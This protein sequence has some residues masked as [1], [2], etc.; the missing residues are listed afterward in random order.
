MRA[1]SAA[2][3]CLLVTG[4]CVAGG[5]VLSGE[6]VLGLG[7][8]QSTGGVHG[9]EALCGTSAFSES[10]CAAQAENESPAAFAAA[11]Q[12]GITSGCAHT[13]TKRLGIP[14]SVPE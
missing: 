11:F 7:G 8:F 5:L 6:G 14:P 13:C 1:W 10:V 2:I 4:G 9:A 3:F 12:Y